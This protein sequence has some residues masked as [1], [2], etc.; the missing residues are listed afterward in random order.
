MNPQIHDIHVWRGDRV[1]KKNTRASLIRPCVPM[2][3]NDIIK[4]IRFYLP[5]RNART[6][7]SLSS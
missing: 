4:T 2:C 7:D 6:R 5:V 3:I 1:T